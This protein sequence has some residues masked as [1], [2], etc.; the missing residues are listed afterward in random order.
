MKSTSFKYGHHQLK[1]HRVN[2]S[3]LALSLDEDFN[4][5]SRWAP[6]VA[7]TGQFWRGVINISRCFVTPG[8]TSP[9]HKGVWQ[10]LTCVQSTVITTKSRRISG[11][12]PPTD[13]VLGIARSTCA[14]KLVRRS[15]AS[16]IW[17]TGWPMVLQWVPSLDFWVTTVFVCAWP[18]WLNTHNNDRTGCGYHSNVLQK[19]PTICEDIN[20]F[21]LVDFSLEKE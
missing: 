7:H 19:A 6:N 16:C 1:V 12:A 2:E 17:W 4:R 11:P 13:V 3:V 8:L 21:P 14:Q 9:T 10:V 18:N 20:V 5:E 15:Q